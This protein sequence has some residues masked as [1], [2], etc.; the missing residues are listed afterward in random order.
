MLCF[1]P[2]GFSRFWP[3]SRLNLAKLK[4]RKLFACDQGIIPKWN[5]EEWFSREW[6]KPQRRRLG[7]DFSGRNRGWIPAQ[8]SP[9][10]ERIRSG[11]SKQTCSTNPYQ[12][13][14]PKNAC[15]AQ[16]ETENSWIYRGPAKKFNSNSN[17]DFQQWFRQ[18][19]FPI[20]A[21]NLPEDPGLLN[22]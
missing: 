21:A 1:P 17:L 10:L 14:E 6:E 2:F 11:H 19:F 15:K 22:H 12:R 18:I 7:E 3:S 16:V 9:I 5:H 8:I 20:N 4:T 13:S